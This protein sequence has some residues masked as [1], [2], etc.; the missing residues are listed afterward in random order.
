MWRSFPFLLVLFILTLCSGCTQEVPAGKRLL[1]EPQSLGAGTTHAYVDLDENKVPTAIGVLFTAGMLD[2]LP[3]APNKTSRCFDLNGDGEIADMGECDGDEE[4]ILWFPE[5]FELKADLPFKYVM[6]NWNPMGHPLPAPPPWAVPHFDF[7][8]YTQDLAEVEAMRTGPCGFYLNCDDFE[9]AIKPVPAKY[10]H[11]DHIDV[12]A[13]VPRMGNHLVNSIS[14][15]LVE[16]TQKF[17]HTWIIGA[18]DGHVTFWEPMITHEFIASRQDVCIAFGQP[19]AWEIGGYYPTSYCIRYI[20]ESD[21]HT[22]SLE[23]L[24]L[25]EAG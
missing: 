4:R 19:E 24:V 9:L 8:F 5:E 1:G 22:V 18:Y 11:P 17:T 14:P 23:G 12:G 21:S 25:R 2:D 13:A 15:E 3:E 10:V 7:H 16:D 20:R 6:L